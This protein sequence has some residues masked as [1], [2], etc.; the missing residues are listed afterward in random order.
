MKKLVK[1]RLTERQLRFFSWLGWAFT[2][3]LLSTVRYRAFKEEEAL[4]GTSVMVEWH[5]QQL[6]GIY[7]FR[8]K[9]FTVISSL[10]RDGDFSSSV[11]R[12]FGWNTVRGSSTRGGARGL[13]ELLRILRRG[14][15]VCLTPD[16]PSGP[17]YHIEPG[18]IY[19]AQKTGVPIVPVSFS[20]ERYWQLKS[21]DQFVI[22]K[23]FTRC[24][25]HYGPGICI[26]KEL[27]EEDFKSYQE[28]VAAAI[29]EANRQGQKELEAWRRRA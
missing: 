27:S 23:P 21:W 1:R 24:V 7:Y 26:P 14:G 8:G 18:C 20:L 4:S 11:L 5:G 25:V 19:L 13:I 10:S 28:Q 29:H 17:I 6:L 15:V 22:P 3:L 12:R 16:G 9:G 2:G